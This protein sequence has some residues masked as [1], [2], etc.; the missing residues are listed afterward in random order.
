MDII[1][2]KVLYCGFVARIKNTNKRVYGWRFAPAKG[3]NLPNL[4]IENTEEQLK[5]DIITKKNFIDFILSED[6]K[7]INGKWK[8]GSFSYN[9][10]CVTSEVWL[11]GLWIGDEIIINIIQEGVI[12]DGKLIPNTE[13]LALTCS[14]NWDNKNYILFL[15]DDLMPQIAT[16]T[17]F[18]WAGPTFTYIKM[19]LRGS[20]TT[21]D[22]PNKIIPSAGEHVQ[23]E[24]DTSNKEFVRFGLNEEIGVPPETLSKSYLLHCGKFDKIGRESRYSTWFYLQDNNIIEF[25]EERYSVA[26]LNAVVIYTEDLVEPKEIDPEDKQEI[27]TK[28]W[29]DINKVLI[30]YPEELWM[31]KD[32]RSFIKPIIDIINEF[33]ELSTEYKNIYKY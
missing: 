1:I 24:H 9:N 16:D 31:C 2:T 21:I 27:K 28:W 3:T 5:P 8:G 4:D 6:V 10:F 15:T 23:P 20:S 25:G 26:Y 13:L 11:S 12:K 30:D 32:H 22:F 29:Y 18:I 14:T 19:L 7:Q 17:V 33:R